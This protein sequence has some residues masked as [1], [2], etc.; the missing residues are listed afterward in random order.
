[1]RFFSLRQTSQAVF[2][3]MGLMTALGMSVSA[4]AATVNS[5]KAQA[6]TTQKNNVALPIVQM[7]SLHW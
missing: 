5:A 2:L 7:A 3:S 4:Q 6:T 1:M